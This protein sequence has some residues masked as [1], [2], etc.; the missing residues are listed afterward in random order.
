[1]TDSQNNYTI[2]VN[3]VTNR[4]YFNIPTP[5]NTSTKKIP[6]YNYNNP[7]IHLENKNIHCDIDIYSTEING[8][9]MDESTGYYTTT[10]TVI[11]DQSNG[12][13]KIFF[14]DNFND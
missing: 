2:P 1:M 8:D 6:G 10:S 7:Y 4:M 5:Y 9:K 12:F 13:D 11:I 14:R 3:T